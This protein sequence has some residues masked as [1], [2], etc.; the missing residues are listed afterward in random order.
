MVGSELIGMAQAMHGHRWLE[1]IA[2]ELGVT[3]R[4][5]RRWAL[6]EQKIPRT[7]ELAVNYLY[8]LHMGDV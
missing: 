1:R 5:V 4:T 7:A 2:G 8:L 6:G 3:G